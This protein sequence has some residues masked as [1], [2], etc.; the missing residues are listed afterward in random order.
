MIQNNTKMLAHKQISVLLLLTI[1]FYV[2]SARILGI[3]HM[4]SKSH[5]ILGSK[6][7]KS[8]A[9]RGHEVTM[10]SPYPFKEKINNYTDIFLEDM[11]RYKEGKFLCN[12]LSRFDPDFL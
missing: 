1:L 4:P 7:L 3:F 6:L 9:E 5:H 12:H 8:L 2:K 11:L 10:V